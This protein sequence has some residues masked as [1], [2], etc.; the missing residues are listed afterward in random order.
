MGHSQNSSELIDI[1]RLCAGA[2]RLR[3]EL[4]SLGQRYRAA[5]ASGDIGAA[6]R[7]AQDTLFAVDKFAIL[8]V[9]DDLD[10]FAAND[11]RLV[12]NDIGRALAS[13]A[14]WKTRRDGEAPHDL[15]AHN[16]WAGSNPDRRA[17]L[18]RPLERQ[19]RGG[20]LSSCLINDFSLPAKQVRTAIGK[21]FGKGASTIADWEVK[22]RDPDGDLS[23][24]AQLVRTEV[25]RALT[26]E[27]FGKHNPPSL[28]GSAL[29]SLISLTVD[30]C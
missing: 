21:A 28:N 14:D 11:A 26:S 3:D 12:V 13:A 1:A 18:H 7:V 6:Q 19:A 30:A 8:T 17:L 15:L 24:I 29:K 23:A 16:E 2:T 25:R 10:R 4:T 22:A 20:A 27:G 9:Q 5:K